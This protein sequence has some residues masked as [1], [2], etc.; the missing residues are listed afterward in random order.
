MPATQQQ[1]GRRNGFDRKQFHE[2]LQRFNA[3]TAEEVD[4]A[5][6]DAF[7][8]SD[9]ACLS[10]SDA[11]RATY[12]H[13]EH[14]SELNDRLGQALEDCVS[15]DKERSLLAEQLAELRSR[16]SVLTAENDRLQLGAR[17]CRGCEWLRRIVAG[18][19]GLAMTTAWLCLFVPH[20]LRP[21]SA[22]V[23][24]AFALGPLAYTFCRWHW[25]LLSK[26]IRWT[27][28][29]DNDLARWWKGLP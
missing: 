15:K 4:A 22:T 19:A 9:R 16:C 6:C 27:S 25:L 11:A 21:W 26:K 14:V 24:G 29:S 7:R 28:W 1:N 10:F 20:G 2:I 5:V 17:F 3:E 8:C 12:G 18:I 13:D 23:A